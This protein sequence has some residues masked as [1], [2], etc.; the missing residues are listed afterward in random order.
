MSYARRVVTRSADAHED[1]DTLAE[2]EFLAARAGGRF[3][4]SWAAHDLHYGVPREIETHLAAG[5]VVVCNVSRGVVDEVRRRY[6][7]SLSCWSRRGPTRWRRASP[8]AGATMATAGASG[9]IALRRS[10][11]PSRPTRRSQNDGALD[12]AIARFRALILAHRN[13]R[14]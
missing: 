10:K 3:A 1:H 2:S 7:H 4:L 13:P 14:P 5:G 12:D 11:T 6:P 9:S 8:R